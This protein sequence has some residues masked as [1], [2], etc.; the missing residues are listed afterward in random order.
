MSEDDSNK[1]ETFFP[2]IK[3]VIEPSRNLMYDT[4]VKPE[5]NILI[6]SKYTKDEKEE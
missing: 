6:D 2:S 3:D 4:L 1:K 5:T